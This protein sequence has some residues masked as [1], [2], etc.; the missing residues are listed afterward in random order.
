MLGEVVTEKSL[1]RKLWCYCNYCKSQGN[2]LV[3]IRIECLQPDST[4][5][6]SEKGRDITAKIAVEPS[7]GDPEV[8]C[9]CRLRRTQTRVW[10]AP[11]SEADKL[12]LHRMCTHMHGKPPQAMPT[13][14]ASTPAPQLPRLS[15]IVARSAPSNPQRNREPS[16]EKHRTDL[17]PCLVPWLHSAQLQVNTRTTK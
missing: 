10:Q 11:A 6:V 1:S 2:G 7:R 12:Q 8:L 3:R 9:R 15:W 17:V 5:L 4:L 14:T 13:R 16:E